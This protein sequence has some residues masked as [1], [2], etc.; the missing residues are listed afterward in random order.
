MKQIFS[1]HHLSESED[2]AKVNT[3]KKCSQE[4]LQGSNPPPPT[5]TDGY[6]EFH[7]NSKDIHLFKT[8]GSFCNYREK[9]PIF[10]CLYTGIF[11][12]ANSHIHTCTITEIYDVYA[13]TL[14]ICKHSNKFK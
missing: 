13:S 14:V 1:Y 2:R 4:K 7:F 5:N 6:W 10:V 8:A 3:H 11:A 12:H 9:S